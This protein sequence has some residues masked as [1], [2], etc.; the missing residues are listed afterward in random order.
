[1]SVTIKDIA[2]IAKV[3]HTTVSRALNDSPFINVETKNKIREI[4]KQLNYTPNYNAKSLVLHRSYNVGLFFSTINNGTSAYFFYEV[5]KGVNSIIMEEYNLIV[6]GVDDYKDFNNI[7]NRNF[8]GIIL[9][10][11]N[12][13]DNAFIYNVLEKKIPLVV[14]NRELQEDYIVNIISGDYKGSRR[15]IEYLIDNGH[16]RI[17][18]IEGKEGF[19]SSDER[20]RGY[21]DALIESNIPLYKDYALRG[22]Y[23]SEGGYEAMKK[24]LDLPI[25]PTA[26]F[27]SNDAMA[28]GAYKA[29][30]EKGLRIPQDISVIGFDDSNFAPYLSPALTTIKRPIEQMSIEGAKS[31]LKIIEGEDLKTE[32]V[33]VK[34]EM[35]IRDS[36]SNRVD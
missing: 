12:V 35:I 26:V 31:L 23:D 3:S 27:C 30:N 33:F 22:N 36:V 6:R 14:L 8:D 20:K 1:M 4:A 10:S 2:K 5:V 13:K 9:M 34:T 32:K 7:S 28:V 19:K 21:L 16:K 25:V 18:I 29:I 11:Q 15:A 24:I 17:A